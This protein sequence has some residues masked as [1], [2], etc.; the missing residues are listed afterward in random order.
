LFAVV[1]VAGVFAAASS[2]LTSHTQ[3]LVQLK[4]EMLFIRLLLMLN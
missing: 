1:V 4:I 2:S 3:K